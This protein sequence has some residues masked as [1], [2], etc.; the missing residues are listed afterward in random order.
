MADTTEVIEIGVD[1][2]E[3]AKMYP[4]RMRAIVLYE[5]LYVF[6]TSYGEKWRLDSELPTSEEE[7]DLRALI[8]ASWTLDTTVVTVTKE[9]A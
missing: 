2:Y 3:V 6:A 9:G 1:S 8:D 5:G 4:S 7:S